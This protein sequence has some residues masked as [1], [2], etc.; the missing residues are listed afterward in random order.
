MYSSYLSL[1]PLVL[2]VAS[3]SPLFG[4]ALNSNPP[5]PLPKNIV[6]L[7]IESCYIVDYL[8]DLN[9]PNKLS[10]QLLQNI[11]DL[12][13]SPPL[14]RIGGHTQDSSVYCPTCTATLTNV[15]SG[16]NDEAKSTT[17]NSNL[18]H[19]LN[20]NVPS[21][22]KFTFGLNLGQNNVN[23]PLAEVQGAEKYILKSR[24]LAYELGNEP[25]QFNKGQRNPW[26][27]NL[28]ATQIVDWINH[29]VSVT[30]TSVPWQVAAFA[31]DPVN[32]NS[33]TLMALN[34]A[35]VPGK[36]KTLR[37]YSSHAYPYSVCGSESLS[38]SQLSAQDAFL[39]TMSFMY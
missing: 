23:I 33:F 13:G 4:R 10:L 25:D 18:Y 26:D 15:F 32:H 24:L 38:S 12:V 29:I 19:V 35:G 31:K 2:P 34:A 36:I 30:G 6:S 28:Y 27:V 37:M 20:D 17:F 21:N 5:V 22:Q 3:G 7:S 16:G 14:I 9:A 8:G 11:Q 1:L 39:C